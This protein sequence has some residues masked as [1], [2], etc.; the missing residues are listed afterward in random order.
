[1]TKN[2]HKVFFNASVILSGLYSPSGG[3]GKLL[4]DIKNRKIKG[5]VSELVLEEIKKNSHKIKKTLSEIQKFEK[6]SEIIILKAPPE[7]DVKKFLEKVKD[8]G[9]AHLFA[10]ALNYKCRYLVSLDK[11][12]V[13]ALKGKIKSLQI[14]SPKE[15]IEELG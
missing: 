11:K 4:A 15:L 8:P 13:L 2:P 1:M 6:Y 9:D 10:S 7:K 3:S 14:R 5:V 12:H